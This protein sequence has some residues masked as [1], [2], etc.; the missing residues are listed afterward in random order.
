MENSTP[1]LSGEVEKL[2]DFFPEPDT[3]RIF[4]PVILFRLLLLQLKGLSKRGLA[5]PNK[6]RPLRDLLRSGSALVLLQDSVSKQNASL[7]LVRSLLPD[8]L[9]PHCLAAL[10]KNR[11]L[12]LFTDSPV[13]ASRLRYFSRDLSNR[14]RKHGVE[15]EKSIIRILIDR[16]PAK[17]ERRH[18]RRLSKANARLL[19]QIAADMDDQE[20]GS[21][22]FRLSKHS[23]Q[24]E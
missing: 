22:L 4:M 17:P 1:S 20:L 24:E 6:P 11:R 21:A 18:V 8:Q 13:W 12:V 19:E 5:M 15:V 3:S 2:P 7:E 23:S 14:L 16:R 9:K 10:I